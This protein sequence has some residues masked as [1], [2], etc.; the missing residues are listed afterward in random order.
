MENS[1]SQEEACSSSRM[2]AC[3]RVSICACVCM[4]ACADTIIVS[5]KVTGWRK[6]LACE[7]VKWPA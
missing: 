6:C 1:V 2:Y 4:Y 3:V 5:G 7:H